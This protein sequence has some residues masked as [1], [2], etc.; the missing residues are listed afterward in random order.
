MRIGN[1]G[2]LNNLVKKEAPEKSKLNTSKEEKIRPAAIYEKSKTDNKTPVYDKVSIDKL[3]QESE[4]VYANLKQMVEE[5]LTKQGKSFDILKTKASIT[6][7]EA[8]RSKAKESISEDGEFG[9]ESM[10]DSIVD[11]A[12]AISGG[13]SSKL[14]KLRDSIEKGFRAAERVLGKLPEI[15]LKTYDRIMEK[16]DEWEKE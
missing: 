6:I 10:S 11:F 5:L 12:K 1:S 14:D 3:K 4:K 8:T 9:I 13:D 7:D 15:S 2:H 16:L